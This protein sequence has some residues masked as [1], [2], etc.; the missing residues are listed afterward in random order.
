MT[1]AHTARNA[2]GYSILKHSM[3]RA[4][5]LKTKIAI[6]TKVDMIG[7]VMMDTSVATHLDLTFFI[8]EGI[9]VNFLSLELV[10]WHDKSCTL[11]C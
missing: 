3:F 2:C 11:H 10:V 5:K 7:S 4:S 6:A 8:S 1:V 9:A